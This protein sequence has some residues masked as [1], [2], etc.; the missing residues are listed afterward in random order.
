M[1]VL[2]RGVVATVQQDGSIFVSW[3]VLGTDPEGVAFSVY[4]GQPGE[5]ATRLTAG[6]LTGPTYFIDPEAHRSQSATY[7]VRP[8]IDGVERPSDGEFTVRATASV[9]PYLTIP[10]DTPEGYHPNDASVG[11]LDGDGQY[12]IVVH[13]VGRGGDVMADGYRTEPIYDGYELD[14]TRLWRI[15][16]GMNIREGAHY[17]PFIVY[18]LDS[19][20]TAELA[21]KT[22][23]GTRDGEGV[24]IGDAAADWRSDSGVVLRGPE[25]L[26]VFD[27]RS[28][29]ALQTAPYLPPRHP[30]TPLGPTP[31][32]YKAVW[33]DDYGNRG[34]RYLSCVA[35]LDGVRPSLVMCRGYYT[36]TVLA[37]WDWRE[38][39]LESRWVFDTAGD[40]PG[41]AAYAGQGNHQVSVADVDSDGRDEIIYGSCA[42]DDDGT[43]LYSTG[44]GHGDAL[45]VSDFD[46]DRPGLEVWQCHES[47]GNGATFR[48]ARTG[49]IIF[50]DPA[51]K[52][53]GRAC[54]GDITAEYPGAE[55]WGSTGCPLYSCRGREIGPSPPQMN[56]VVWWDGD[57]LRELLDGTT[58]SKYG[59]GVI[60]EAQGCAPNNG[61]KSTPCL[62]ADI[63]GDWREEVLWRTAD[64]RALR[65][66]T[67]DMPTDHRLPTLMHDP[68]YRLAVAWQNSGYNQPPHPGFFLGEGM[69]P[70]RSRATSAAP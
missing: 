40:T 41:I 3:R 52:D 56:F 34:E 13:M 23:D 4:R 60:L 62:Q 2:D 31:Q 10:V 24:V 29:R 15:N 38:D 35:Y 28:G 63:I 57:L 67:T 5:L 68:Q 43:G 9:G 19:D 55:L 21:C 12:E 6:P 61:T 1:E 16:L 54:G 44:L 18:D 22:A 27:G 45:H 58:I 11:D 39:R 7:E 25:F 30:T 42:I 36:R 14:G 33:G 65:L 8:V 49:E 37:A 69:S 20:G 26:T 66:Y 64:N 32:E 59:L 53:M 51:P 46:P 47:G 48:D 70:P 50:Q 17:T